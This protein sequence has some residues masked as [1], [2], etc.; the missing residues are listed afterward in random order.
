MPRDGP[1]G[2][3]LDEPIDSANRPVYRAQAIRLVGIRRLKGSE[4]FVTT[5]LATPGS[6]PHV[7]VVL[8]FK[9]PG[10]D[11]EFNLFDTKRT[12]FCVYTYRCLSEFK[13][14][15]GRRVWLPATVTKSQLYDIKRFIKEFLDTSIKDL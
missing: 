12:L 14:P 1:Y 11:S 6:D 2:L 13:L 8:E 9:A 15:K 5:D 7:E 10:Q 4:V 3:K